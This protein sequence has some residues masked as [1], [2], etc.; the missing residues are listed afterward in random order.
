M[1]LLMIAETYASID[2]Y[3]SNGLIPIIK[4]TTFLI[5]CFTLPYIII[6]VLYPKDIL[7]VF[8]SDFT[9]YSNVLI[10]L[11][12]GQLI[13]VATGSVGKILVMSGSQYK[14]LYSFV[15][16]AVILSVLAVF[17]IM[18]QLVQLYQHLLA[19]LLLIL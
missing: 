17:I 14:Q 9:N 12:L 16:G 18:V 4:K 7:L 15:I 5:I 1:P 8:G 10:I 13:N 2:K 19:L 6:L 3:K 11:A